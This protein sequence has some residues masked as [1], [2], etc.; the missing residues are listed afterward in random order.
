MGNIFNRFGPEIMGLVYMSDHI[1]L[2]SVKSRGWTEL[3]IK[4]WLGKPDKVA[5]NP[6][7]RN[8]PP[9]KLFLLK[10]VEEIESGEEWIKWSN[11]TKNK[12]RT[13]GEK[14]KER[15]EKKRQEI[16]DYIK[17][18]S[19]EINLFEKEE[20]YRLACKHYNCLWASRGN[21]EK[22]ADLSCSKP[23][24]NRIAVNMLR[25]EFSQYE[26]ELGEIFGKI[27]KDLAY[28]ELK[29]LVLDKIKE[30]YP[31]LSEECD[32]QKI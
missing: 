12:R 28:V 14:S 16:L 15:A 3:A 24:L 25:H 13:I 9:M 29:N 5:K 6:H 21:F 32:N 30:K 4:K 23:F 10:R 17:N 22:C 11:D 7:G 1:T 18:L 26:E 19:I 2:S 31:F 8:A 27:G 20:L